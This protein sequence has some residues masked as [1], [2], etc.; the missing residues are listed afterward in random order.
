MNK[1]LK[2]LKGLLDATA[3]GADPVE[4]LSGHLCGP[5]CLHW[6]SLSEERKRKLLKAPWNQEV[7]SGKSQ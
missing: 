2:D 6:G 5:G 4:A 7:R 3:H 1:L